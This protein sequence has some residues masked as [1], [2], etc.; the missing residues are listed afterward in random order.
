VNCRSCGTEI[1][2]KALICYRCGTATTEA[3]YKPASLPQQR[4]SSLS[5]LVSVIAIILLALPVIGTRL[6]TADAS[7]ASKSTTGRQAYDLLTTGFGAG[8]NGPVPIVVDQAA[9]PGA[10]QKIYTAAQKLPKS[11]AAFVQ[12]P[13]YNK[14]KD[15]GLVVISPAT[16][17]QDK[18]TD[19]LISK[20]RDHTVPDALA[21]SGAHAYVSGQN[22]AFIDISNR[23]YERAPWFLLY[24]IGVTVIVLSMAFRSLVIAFKAAITTLIS[25]TIGFAVLTAVFKMGHGLNLIGLDRTGPIESFVPPIA[26]AILFGLSM[27]YE[28][29]L[30]SRIREEHIHGKV[31]RD[32]VRDG[33]A[34]IGRVVFAAAIIMSAVFFAFMLAPDRVSKE[35]GL[36][37]AVAILCD[38]LIMR[39]TVVPALLTQLGEKSWY[40][41]RWL[42]KVLPN[43]TIEPPTERSETV[44]PPAGAPRPA[45]ES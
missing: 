20:L 4:R 8:F 25:A 35:F 28:V 39:L 34:A 7:T 3:K 32:A 18:E 2:D 45:T 17:P 38:A 15:V 24:I 10:S 11:M 19:D 23:I 16:K 40:I 43:I 41:P 29:F 1:A 26:F 30:M 42:D 36:L 5:L 27:D 13:I 31:T 9:D 21:G 37:L 14:S 44:T 33:V 12:K 22:A 6:G